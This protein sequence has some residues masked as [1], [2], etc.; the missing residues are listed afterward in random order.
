MRARS[1]I[2][3]VIAVSIAGAASRAARAQGRCPAPAGA[4]PALAEMDPHL[5]LDWIDARLGRAAHKARVW[6]RGWGIGI[7]VA[8]VANL[9]PLAFV[10]PEDRID[11]YVGA[12]TTVVG[13]VPLVIA[14]LDVVGDARELHARVLA[15][16]GTGQDTCALLADAETRLARD[17]KNQADG[18]RWWLHAG[19]V[20]L[21]TG[22]GLFLALGYNHWLAGAFN[23]VIGSAIGEALI[24][25]QPTESIDDLRRYRSGAL[26]DA[27]PTRLGL[28]FT[29]RF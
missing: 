9:V 28:A 19:N 12:A 20:V 7:G 2:V 5:R 8:T 13:I 1:L 25:T 23:A 11:W 22:V 15:A 27:A 17:A 21:N 18:Q 6:T 24:L 29:A 16:P 10:A 14:P 26:E 3:V 4:T